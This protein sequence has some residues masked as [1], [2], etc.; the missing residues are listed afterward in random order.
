MN[1]GGCHGN[2]NNTCVQNSLKLMLFWVFWVHMNLEWMGLI[3]TSMNDLKF[4]SL[5]GFKG[6][7]D[8]LVMK[9][10]WVVEI[11]FF[12]HVQI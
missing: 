4:M 12:G 8:F 10:Y 11:R 6:Y 3:S 1:L 7:H 9:G 5:W 2:S